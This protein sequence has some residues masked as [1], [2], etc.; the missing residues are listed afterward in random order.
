VPN[1]LR[2]R[3]CSCG[4]GRPARRCCGWFRRVGEG[5]AAA[6]YLGRQTR[7]ARDVL[8][9]FAPSAIAALQGEAATLMKLAERVPAALLAAGDAVAAD[10]RRIARALARPGGTEGD[11]MV[12][13]AV[14]RADTAP[15]RATVARLFLTLREAGVVDEHLAA[16]ALL[17]LIGERSRVSE[18]ALLE[19]GKVLAGQPTGPAAGQT[20]PAV[21]AAPDAVDLGGDAPGSLDPV[22]V[23]R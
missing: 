12:R 1:L 19:A 11:L 15:A 6:A 5:E 8:A 23:T 7:G 3:P 4:S 20:G 17:D 14:R 2:N 16:A 9:P 22:V 18:A 10:V 21:G 13:G